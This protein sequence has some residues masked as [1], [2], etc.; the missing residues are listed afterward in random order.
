MTLNKHCLGR[1]RGVTN[2]S[3]ISE[4]GWEKPGRQ[5]PKGGVTWRRA[6]GWCMENNRTVP[7]ASPE[8]THV[9]EHVRVLDQ[10]V[11]FWKSSPSSRF[12]LC[13]L[14]YVVYRA[15]GSAQGT[16]PRWAPSQLP[17]QIIPP[18]R[19]STALPFECPQLR[20]WL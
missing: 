10:S 17:G 14:Q 16:R 13:F 20:T 1:P 9:K 18:D 15:S 3:L 8:A 5:R 11:S 2:G 7:R 12:L 4:E 6:R 19:C